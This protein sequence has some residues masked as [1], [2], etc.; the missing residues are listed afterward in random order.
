MPNTYYDGFGHQQQKQAQQQQQQQ[1]YSNN[2]Y[3]MYQQQPVAQGN[4]MG[5]SGAPTGDT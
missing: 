2:P 4:F 5:G 1:Q 3:D